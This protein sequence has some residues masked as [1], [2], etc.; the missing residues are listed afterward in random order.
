M[1]LARL[2]Y[3]H[4]GNNVHI[5]ICHYSM[6]QAPNAITARN[7]HHMQA[8][9]KVKYLEKSKYMLRLLLVVQYMIEKALV[10]RY[11]LSLDGV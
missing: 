5:I 9:Y 1:L 10:D 4:E 2:Q 11:D 3:K 7:E 6:E 8:F